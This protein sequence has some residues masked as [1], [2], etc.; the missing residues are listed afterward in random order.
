MC[1]GHNG[2]EFLLNIYYLSTFII[3]HCAR[4][5]RTPALGSVGGWCRVRRWPA[6]AGSHLVAGSVLIWL[7][8]GCFVRNKCSTCRTWL[9]FSGRWWHSLTQFGYFACSIHQHIWYFVSN[10]PDICWTSLPYFG[11]KLSCVCLMFAY[12]KKIAYSYP[13]V[14]YSGHKFL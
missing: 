9:E 6:S 11:V 1:S 4:C 8:S 14:T 10:N 13:K 3:Y 7:P 5:G 12:R 2:A